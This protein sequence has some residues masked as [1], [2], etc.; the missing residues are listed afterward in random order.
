MRPASS[1]QRVF[2]ILIC[3]EVICSVSI[4]GSASSETEGYS[5]KKGAIEI[6]MMAGFW[7]ATTA[8]GDGPSAN[9]SAAFVLPRL[10]I[11]VTDPLGTDWWRG[12]LEVILEPVYAR[13]TQPFAADLAG[14]SVLA[15]YNLLS[16]AKWMP[17]WDIG[18]G[19]VWTNLAPRI[20]EESAPFEF[21]LETGPGVHYFVTNTLTLT[22]GVRLSH[23]SNAGIG[24]RNTG[25]NAVLPYLGVSFFLPR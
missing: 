17:F 5:A 1:V 24:T 25:I 4:P 15:K 13:F 11:V 2:I 14:A 22:M 23:I 8:I 20:P 16:F 10:G 3:I 12:N 19:M 7:Q 6:G 9:R 21:L 18:A